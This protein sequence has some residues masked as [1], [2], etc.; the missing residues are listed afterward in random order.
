MTDVEVIVVCN[1]S[2]PESAALVLNAGAP[3]K[4][5]WSTEALG[6]TVAANIGFKLATADFIVILNTDAHILDYAPKDEWMNRLL[7]PFADPKV[8]ITGL[9]FMWSNIGTY[10]P[11]YCTG[12]RRSLFDELGYLDE[13]FSPGYGE[14]ADFCYRIRKAGYELVQVDHYKPVADNSSTVTNF[15]IW[16]PGEQ[17]FMDKE[18]RQ[19]YVNNGN[20][21]LEEKWGKL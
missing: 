19:Q 6:F 11:F 2:D 13:R 16:H 21:I 7:Q 18:K 5:F 15:P 10:A 12:I 9:G 1:G 4:L 8:G 14:D 20:K 17:S 3:F